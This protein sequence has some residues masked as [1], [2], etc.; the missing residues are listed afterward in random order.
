MLDQLL[1]Q[2]LFPVPVR[3]LDCTVHV[4]YVAVAETGAEAVSAVFG[5]HPATERQS[6]LERF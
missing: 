2:P 1:L 6:V 5:R 4:G 3:V